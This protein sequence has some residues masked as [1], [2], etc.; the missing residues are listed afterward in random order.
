MLRSIC[1][2]IEKPNRVN[3]S[4]PIVQRLYQDSFVWILM[5]DIVEP[6][7]DVVVD[8]AKIVIFD[9]PFIDVAFNLIN[10]EE[11]G[12][13][14]FMNADIAYEP[15]RQAF[16]FKV[17]L[18]YHNLCPNTILSKIVGTNLETMLLGAAKLEF[19][20]DDEVNDFY[21]TLKAICNVAVAQDYI[22]SVYKQAQAEA[23][24]SEVSL[25][26]NSVNTWWFLGLIE[27]MLE[28]ARGSDWSTYQQL[29]PLHKELWD[30]IE[31]VREKEGRDGVSYEHLLRIHS[32]ELKPKDIKLVEESLSVNRV[33]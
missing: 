15:I 5:K 13:V 8:N 26:P 21:N 27:K 25:G 32:D 29:A 4:E 12:D 18:E 28:P 30:R 10:H 33:W 24:P 3:L 31:K 17:A 20:N 23:N 14:I 19:K 2:D 1:F 7:E 6:L 11:L 22:P 16:L 9:S